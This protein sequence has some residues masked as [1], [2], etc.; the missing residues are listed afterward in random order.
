MCHRL[1]HKIRVRGNLS[2][3][4]RRNQYTLTVCKCHA[5][6]P[7]TTTVALALNTFGLHLIDREVITTNSPHIPKLPLLHTQNSR[8]N[9]EAA[10]RASLCTSFVFLEIPSCL[11]NS[12]MYSDA[13]CISL[14]NCGVDQTTGPIFRLN[15][16]NLHKRN[17]MVSKYGNKRLQQ[18]LNRAKIKY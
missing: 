13:F 3:H 18:C 10:P 17:R 2:N 1:H 8:K 5:K 9:C 15:R 14:P 11:Y 12:T 7:E 6:T 4:L 16:T